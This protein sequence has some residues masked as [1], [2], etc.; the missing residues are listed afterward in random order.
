M[1]PN[2]VAVGAEAEADIRAVTAPDVLNASE[3]ED[4]SEWL[5]VERGSQGRLRLR[6]SDAAKAEVEWCEALFAEWQIEDF[7]RNTDHM[8]QKCQK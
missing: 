3:A 1:K 5:S 7:R 4:E 2:K 8:D 6:I